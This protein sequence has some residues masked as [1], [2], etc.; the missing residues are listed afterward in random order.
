MSRTGFANA[1]VCA[2]GLVVGFA[3][4]WSIVDGRSQLA[5]GAL[6]LLVLLAVAILISPDVFNFSGGGVQ[7]S[8]E[9]RQRERVEEVLAGG[10]A[11]FEESSESLATPSQPPVATVSPVERGMGSTISREALR[12][13]AED[14]ITESAEWGWMMGQIGFKSVPRPVIEWEG[15]QP[16]IM[17]G[18]GDPAGPKGGVLSGTERPGYDLPDKGV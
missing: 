8:M 15:D 18:Q 2:T 13:Y 6:A 3:A 5:F 14:L 1:I 12:R 11:A 7:A 10:T 17:Y 4:V 9:R 16:K